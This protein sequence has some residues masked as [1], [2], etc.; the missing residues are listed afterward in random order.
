MG[1]FNWMHNRPIL[2]II[3][4]RLLK[5][6]SIEMGG[7]YVLQQMRVFF[8]FDKDIN[9]YTSFIDIALRYD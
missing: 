6:V 2:H 9:T 4:D 1:N 7:K 5:K 3:F 8:L